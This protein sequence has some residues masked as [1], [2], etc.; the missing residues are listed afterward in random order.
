MSN[1][2]NPSKGSKFEDIVREFFS[3]K[4]LA[5]ESNFS[6]GVGVSS[7][8][9]PR[10]FDL[11]CA[12][13]PIIVECKSHAWTEGGN[14]PSAKLSVWNEAMLYFLAAPTQYRKI[15]VALQ[16]SRGEESL[17]EH[18][19]KRFRHLV[20]RGVEIWEVSPDGKFGRCVYTGA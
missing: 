10:K 8:H 7:L 2:D 14:A 18:Y 3:H 15:F 16:H 6:V 11:G 13:P 20:P 12:E 17:A 9:K 1:A 5:L 4:G 19:V